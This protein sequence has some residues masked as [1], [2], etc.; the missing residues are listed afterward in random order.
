MV[1]REA[2]ASLSHLRQCQTETVILLLGLLAGLGSATLAAKQMITTNPVQ[3]KGVL[4]VDASSPAFAIE[5][6]KL[7]TPEAIAKA[8]SFLPQSLI[9]I[10]NTDQY[11]W[12]F[13]VVYRYPEWIAPA[14][15]RG[16]IVLVLPRGEQESATACFL[17]GGIFWLHRFRI[18]LLQQPQVE[19]ASCNP[20]LMK[21][22]TE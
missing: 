11:I 14:G 7:L 15:H 16:S 4:V 3:D 10:N 6:Q 18:F 17:L 12:G 9:V 21:G 20:T 8:S 19:V 1:E 2:E 13:T 5:V 22:W